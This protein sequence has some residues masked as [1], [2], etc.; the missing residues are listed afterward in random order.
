VKL[1]FRPEDVHLSPK[2]TM[3]EGCRRLA[4]GIIEQIS[5][6]GAYER[7]TLRLDLT[8]RQPGQSE[9]PLY[10]LTITTLDKRTGIPVV[11]TRPK[12]EASA[13]PL[14]VGDRVAIGLTAFRVLPN[15]ALA[16]ERASRIVAFRK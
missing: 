7:L 5:F 4:N 8:E 3:P 13:L 14:K 2:G 6:V 15:Y 11:V 1:V 9:P 12:P 10:K 16:S